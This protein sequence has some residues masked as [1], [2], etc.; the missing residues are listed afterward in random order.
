VSFVKPW[1]RVV[2]E[3]SYQIYFAIFGHSYKFIRFLK[4]CTIFWKLNQLENDCTDCTVPGQIRPGATVHRRGGLPC[5]AGRKLARPRHGGPVQPQ[6]DPRAG[7]RGG[8][9]LDGPVVASR[10]QC[11]AGELVGTTGRAPGKEGTDGARRREKEGSMYRSR[12]RGRRRARGKEKR[13]RARQL[14][15]FEAKA[16]EGWGSGW[17]PHRAND[18]GG[19]G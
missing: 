16:G 6:S 4:I 19:G 3:G 9:L 8:T 15:P 17:W 14:A 2:Q 12:G 7:R 5:A 1:R 13:A 11:V 10:R 18:G